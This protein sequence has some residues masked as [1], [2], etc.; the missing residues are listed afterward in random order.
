MGGKDE[1]KLIGAIDGVITLLNLTHTS[2]N[3][4]SKH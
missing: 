2:I 4:T 3:N 1:K